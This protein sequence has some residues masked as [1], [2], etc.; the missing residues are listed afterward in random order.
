MTLSVI[1]YWR[2]LGEVSNH[3]IETLQRAGVSVSVI[4]DEY[5]I[6]TMGFHHRKWVKVNHDITITTVTNEQ[7]AWLILCFGD[8]VLHLSTWYSSN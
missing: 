6:D 2:L 5:P 8:R 1:K 7:E 4:S 3:D